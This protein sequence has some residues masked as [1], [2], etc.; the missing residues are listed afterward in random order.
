M[1]LRARR[2]GLLSL[3]STAALFT[4]LLL[5]VK[6]LSESTA[7]FREIKNGT[8]KELLF[9]S[10]LLAQSLDGTLDIY[11]LILDGQSG[12]FD[13]GSS[14]IAS[15]DLRQ[16]LRHLPAAIQALI[17]DS[18]GSIV[19][20]PPGQAR[21]QIGVSPDKLDRIALEGG[22]AY[23]VTDYGEARTPILAAI[24]P[25]G[26]GAGTAFIVVL[27][28]GSASANR[29]RLLLQAGS[30]SV[31]IIDGDG[32]Q[33]IE[34]GNTELAEGREIIV[35]ETALASHPI[36]IRVARDING[37]L[38]D[39]E[40]RQAWQLGL[41]GSLAL[42]A[43][44]VSVGALFLSR[45]ARKTGELEAELSA[46]DLL[47]HE[48]NHRVKNNLTTVQAILALSEN[49][50]EEADPRSALV[51]KEASEKIRSI[52]MLHEQLYKRRSLS[53]IDLGDYIADLVALLRD[54]Y[55][56]DE[57]IDIEVAADPGIAAALDAAVPL[58]LI[59][60]ELVTNAFKHAFPV[61]RKG[62]IRITVSKKGNGCEI[63]VEDNGVG[64]ND[65]SGGYGHTLIEGLI[66]Q[67]GGAMQ[68]DL[69]KQGLTVS[70]TVPSLAD[71][72]D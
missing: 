31:S 42:I 46:R 12:Q 43:A 66:A 25:I 50:L 35:S 41:T 14:N 28:S 38:R 49:E 6:N 40:R 7:A 67:L 33:F 51:L 63:V 71:H 30:S 39:W 5:G 21:F 4:I 56:R 24:K 10:E 55:A 22:I 48:V 70:L 62:R 26:T 45:R 15:L 60:T 34:E 13:A 47:F 54:S 9:E 59:L 65:S 72:M 64:L 27:F 8:S 37:E 53:F 23:L 44:A 57:R 20:M 2:L 16:L 68:R 17:L 1:K 58:A 29:L 18:S 61:G 36:R 69:S 3:G 32:R 19:A 11:D 52:S